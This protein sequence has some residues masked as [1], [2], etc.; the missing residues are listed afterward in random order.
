MISAKDIKILRDKTG[1]G[2]LDSKKALEATEGDIEKA[3]DYLREKGIL[4]AQK[5]ADRIATEGLVVSYQEGNVYVILEVN[6]ETDFV[7]KNNEFVTFVDDI[8]KQIAKTNPADVEELKAQKLLIDESKTVGDYLTDKIAVIG[9]NLS[10]RRFVRY[11][12]DK[13][14]AV[15]VHGGRIGA[16][17]EFDGEAAVAKDIAMQVAASNPKFL[18][19][20]EVSQEEIEHEKEVLKQQALNEGKPENIVEKMVVGRMNKYFSEVCLLDQPFIKDSDLSVSKYIKGKGEVLRFARLE[21][22]EGLEKKEENFAE[23][24]AKQ[25]A[26]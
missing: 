14:V 1:A 17:V 7:A 4:K 6:S 23:E 16:M 5:K 10:I 8:A 21:L 22:G 9:E 18:S 15:Y 20:D 25:M 19:R 26:K 24:V 13:E 12:S 2:I 11:E 3:I